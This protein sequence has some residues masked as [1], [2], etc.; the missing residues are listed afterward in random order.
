[1][2]EVWAVLEIVRDQCWLNDTLSEISWVPEA[3]AGLPITEDPDKGATEEEL[4]AVLSGQ[5]TKKKTSL[6]LSNLPMGIRHIYA[7]FDTSQRLR[8]TRRFRTHF[9]RAPAH[10]WDGHY[11][12]KP[13]WSR[14]SDSRRPRGH[15]RGCPDVSTRGS[16]PA[17]RRPRTSRASM[18]GFS[19]GAVT[20]AF[21]YFPG[22]KRRTLCCAIRCA[23]SLFYHTP[24][25][26]TLSILQTPF[27]FFP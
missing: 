25:I 13:Q 21:R 3:I 12:R 24:F 2:Q 10:A 16:G 7:A 4:R 17:R 5:R 8:R 15:G 1:M 9:P 11:L 19:S 23:H 20:S 26:H 18:G 6:P 14:W 22:G 27:F